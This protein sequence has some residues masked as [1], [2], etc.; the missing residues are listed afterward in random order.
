MDTNFYNITYKKNYGCNQMIITPSDTS[1]PLN[2]QLQSNFRVRMIKENTIDGL[3]PT[4][5]HFTDGVPSFCYDINGLQSL[6]VILS[7][8]PL[9]YDLLTKIFLGLYNALMS[10]EKYMLIFEHILPD[11]EC[12]FLS[13][14]YS[15]VY[16]CYYP[17]YEQDFATSTGYIF[18]ELLKSVD[19]SDEKCVYLAYTMNKECHTTDFDIHRLISCLSAIPERPL[20]V[21]E[22][23][24][25]NL[26]VTSNLLKEDMC[27]N[28][29]RPATPSFA[30][31]PLSLQETVKSTFNQ[32]NKILY[33]KIS[34]LAV[35]LV[36][37]LITI[38]GLFAYGLY[39]VKVFL[40][41]FAIILIV[42]GYNGYMIYYLHAP[43]KVSSVI[44]SKGESY[45]LPPIQTIS[46]D[47]MTTTLLTPI[48]EDSIYKLVYTG[49]D[50]R[51]D[52]DLKTFPF[53]IGKSEACDS[54]ITDPTVSR[55][56]AKI[57]MYPE[58]SGQMGLFIED[59]NST[60]GTT[61]NNTPLAPYSKAPLTTGDLISFG[62]IT[63]LL[64]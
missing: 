1:I 17:V 22:E 62:G 30:T 49:A 24:N 20:W 54:Y 10:V 61:L 16:F 31:A 48:D 11:T 45:G 12:I 43:S 56:H 14:D 21:A 15:Q 41:L 28:V 9:N 51:H 32:D 34:I 36:V 4:H 60:N 64:R 50:P 13:A 58:G 63:Y 25:S 29:T 2:D 35:A 26:S 8:T 3:L 40:V 47:S 33:I 46:Q 57:D 18:D 27:Y 39:G 19:H 53:V 52:I 44:A 23:D 5:L 7:S 38:T 37:S 55:I 59:L 6:K 42:A